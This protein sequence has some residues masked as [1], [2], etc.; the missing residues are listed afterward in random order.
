MPAAQS[1]GWGAPHYHAPMFTTKQPDPYVRTAPSAQNAVD[2]FKGEW[3]SRLPP[4]LLGD[5]R[6]GEVPL[7]DDDRIKWAIEQ[8][9]GARDFTALELGPLEGGHS[10]MLERQGAASV[11][12]IEANVRAY[13][14]CLITKELLGLQRVNF[15]CGDFVEYLRSTTNRFDVIVASGVL[16]HMRDPVELLALMAA[17]ADNL[18]VWTQYYD[19]S[20][21]RGKSK[22]ALK[23]SSH[24]SAESA[25]FRYTAHRQEYPRRL[26]GFCGGSESYSI[27]LSRPDLLGALAHVGFKDVRI[28]HEQLDHP[29]GP[30]F[31]FVAMK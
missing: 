22:R 11:L 28:A 8:F 5:V 14:K 23:F 13:L 6:A 1:H 12:A 19:E 17:H 27:W 26:S 29:N 10:Y 21:V 9:G 2:I 7:F 15:L 20:M 3:A 24:K 31:S 25:G 4:T 16:Y 18:F 30:C